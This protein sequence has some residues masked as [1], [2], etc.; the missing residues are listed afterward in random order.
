MR[1]IGNVS[2]TITGPSITG[3]QARWMSSARH[4]H[5][6]APSEKQR[7]QRGEGLTTAEPDG[8]SPPPLPSTS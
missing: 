6:H 2:E 5:R 3:N 7:E 4:D 8:G 1:R